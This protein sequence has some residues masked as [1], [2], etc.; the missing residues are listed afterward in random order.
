[1]NAHWRSTLFCRS[2][3]RRFYG[4]FCESKL[5]SAAVIHEGTSYKL[6]WA[7]FKADSICYPNDKLSVVYFFK[8]FTGHPAVLGISLVRIACPL[9]LSHHPLFLSTST[10]LFFCVHPCPLSVLQLW[11]WGP[12]IPYVFT[13]LSKTFV[14]VSVPNPVP[15][16]NPLIR[17]VCSP[18]PNPAPWP[19]PVLFL[20]VVQPGVGLFEMSEPV[21]G[22][23][24]RRCQLPLCF[25]PKHKHLKHFSCAATRQCMQLKTIGPICICI[26]FL[27]GNVR[28]NSVIL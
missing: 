16:S 9:P 1:M 20:S 24:C 8:V 26:P 3:L 4:C 22:S 27:R 13:L 14:L 6:F 12:P 18:P 21:T 28:W 23:P 25:K 15:M 7:T 2:G 10:S 11:C 5:T 19:P 17:A